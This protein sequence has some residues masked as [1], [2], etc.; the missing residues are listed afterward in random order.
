R[1]EPREDKGDSLA[2]VDGELRNRAHVLTARLHWRA[3]A[4]RVRARE[5]DTSVLLVRAL[6]HPGD[7][8]SV[9]EA[10]RQVRAEVDAALHAFDD[11]HEVGRVA[12]RRHEVEDACD[13]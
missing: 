3:K 1:G 8:A 9:V 5:S 13:A 4:K 2:L 11:A 6:A 7:D 12:A 10:D